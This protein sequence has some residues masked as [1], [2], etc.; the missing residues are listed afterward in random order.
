HLVQALVSRGK[1]RTKNL[2]IVTRGAFTIDS[3]ATSRILHQYPVAALASTIALEY[4]ELNCTHIDLDPLG[5]A[6]EV[7]QLL[8]AF[9]S[10]KRTEERRVAFRRGR[11]FVA[12]LTHSD[13]P[14]SEASKTT[15][16]EAG[17]RG[18]LTISSDGILEHL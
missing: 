12:R 5:A 18:H 10:G 7:E 15:G 9:S 6:G 11:R 8:E 14:L 4:P 2:R 17:S 13:A 16:K 3:D 1:A